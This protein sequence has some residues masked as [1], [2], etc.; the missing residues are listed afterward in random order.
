VRPN[1]TRQRFRFQQLA[2]VV[3]SVEEIPEPHAFA[4][5]LHHWRCNGVGDL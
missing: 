2:G 1:G 4:V 3:E 5:T